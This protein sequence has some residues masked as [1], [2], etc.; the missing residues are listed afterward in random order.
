MNTSEIHVCPFCKAGVGTKATMFQ[1]C[2]AYKG[3][4]SKTKMRL[5]QMFFIATSLLFA[6]LLGV[7]LFG[8]AGG[9]Y[10]SLLMA[11]GVSLK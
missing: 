8:M 10:S 6:A 1:G 3:M 7:G 2:G 5:F 4:T 9:D 11:S